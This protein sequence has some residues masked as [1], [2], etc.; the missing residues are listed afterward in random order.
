MNSQGKT[1]SEILKLSGKTTEGGNV[2]S[3]VAFMTASHG[4]PLEIILQKLRQ[5]NLTCDWEDYIAVCIKDGHNITTI[6]AR[7]LAAVGD[8]YGPVYRNE[9]SIRLESFLRTISGTQQ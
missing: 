9:F 6:R 2:V 5:H 1:R 4:V 3:G 7:I 8:V